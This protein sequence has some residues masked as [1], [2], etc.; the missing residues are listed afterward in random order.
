[1]TSG[2]LYKLT[3]G[4]KTVQFTGIAKVSGGPEIDDAVSEDVEEVVIDFNKNIDY[5]TGTDVNNYSINGVEILKA[6]VDGDEVT[7]TTEGL[8]DRT[9]Y[10]V[11]LLLLVLQL[12]HL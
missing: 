9:K 3:V 2:K 11:K 12:V 6:E 7:L 1:M 4:E 5:A 10:T 8:K